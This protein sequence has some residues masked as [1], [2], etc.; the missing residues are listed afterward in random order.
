MKFLILAEDYP[1]AANPY[2]L[3]YIHSR[4]IEY[5]N[6]GEECLVL[7]FSADSDYVFEGIKV[8]SHV[9][10]L[11]EFD[12]VI[13]HAPNLKNH[14]IYILRHLSDITKIVFWIHGHEVMNVYK[15]YP[16]AYPWAYKQR[17]T[18][19][20]HFLYS[21]VKLYFMRYIIRF[22]MRMR[23]VRFVFV[24]KWM[25]EIFSTNIFE[26]DENDYSVIPNPINANFLSNRTPIASVNE[27]KRAICI[28]P[29]D[30]SK[31][32]VDMVVSFALFNPQ[33]QFDIYGSGKF[34]NHNSVPKNVNFI[35]RFLVQSE[36]VEIVAHYDFAILPTRLD[37]Q[38]VFACEVAT[39]GMPII[40]N[41]IPIMQEVLFGFPNVAFLPA[42]SFKEEYL[43]D[44]PTRSFELNERYLPETIISSELEMLYE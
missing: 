39:S 8:V 35:S 42:E 30:N 1:S 36:L 28:R 22:L 16:K 2:A 6:R 9:S 14:M 15:Q 21:P 31:Y 23:N 12:L 19:L 18:K 3:A 13:S 33:F 34:P 7:S 37:A 20:L 11:G 17:F 5:V 40:V 27:N 41:D 4:L 32:A 24:S 29:W 44:L 10:R 38:G 43:D 25:Y 26:L